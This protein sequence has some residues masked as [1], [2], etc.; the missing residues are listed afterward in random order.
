MIGIISRV[1]AELPNS[2]AVGATGRPVGADA[3]RGRS[4]LVTG[5]A[6]FIGSHLGEALIASGC[7]LRVLD[8]LSTGRTSNVP[9]GAD[10]IQGSVTDRS[11][12]ARAVDGVDFVFHLAALVS[13]PV[14]VAEP[15][16]CFEV[17]VTGTENVVR[18]A[19]QAGV[20]GLVHVS[21]AA[22]YGASPSL[23][24]RESDP[25]SC[26]SPYASSKACGEF[27]V[28]AAARSAGLRGASLRFFNVF[29]PRQDPKSAYAAVISAFVDA[30]LAG[31]DPTIFGD[32][33][34]TRDFVPVSEVVKA[35][36]LAAS[37]AEEVAGESFNVGLGGTT[38]IRDL[39]DRIQAIAGTRLRTSFA[40]RRAGD[41]AHSCASIDKARLLLGYSPSRSVSDGL[42]ELVEW[43]RAQAHRRGA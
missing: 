14:S 16:R 6:G 15:E 12:V 19:T 37:R 10:F 23:P 40:P 34:A 35:M 33:S 27:L 24:S 43:E 3:Y 36:L 11:I 20:L 8:D 29:G 28:Q 42:A 38:T 32:G 41:V 21:S 1:N 5:G 17:N 26:Q 7:R 4:A 22:V 39:L 13:V 25:I 31:R 30:A 18:S 9:L 2:L